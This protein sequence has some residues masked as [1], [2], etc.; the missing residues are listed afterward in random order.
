MKLKKHEDESI[1]QFQFRVH[2]PFKLLCLNHNAI[3]IDATKVKGHTNAL[4]EGRVQPI[5]E[6]RFR[7]L[8][9]IQLERPC[10]GIN[11]HITQHHQDIFG[12]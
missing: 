2:C 9:E 3:A 5:C 1:T 12:I 4:H 11:V 7:Q 10:Y 8:P 6:K